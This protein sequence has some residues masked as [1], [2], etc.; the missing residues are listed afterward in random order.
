MEIDHCS[1]EHLPFSTLFKTY[2]NKFSELRDF[3][4]YD[5]FDD[6]SILDRSEFLNDYNLR[7]ELIEALSVYHKDLCISDNQ[8]EQ[9]TKFANVD[10]RVV[11][12]GQQT[13]LF[14]GPLFTVYKTLTTILLA[15]KMESITGKPVVPV[16]WI[17]DEDHDFDEIAWA[18][19]LGRDDYHA[20]TLD[21]QGSG[22]PV[23][24]EIIGSDFNKFESEFWDHLPDTDFT[25]SLK[26]QLAE[27][28][29]S[30]NTFSASFAQF[31]CELFA[32]QGILIAGSQHKV[33]KD[34]SKEVIKKSVT[35]CDKIFEAIET[36]SQQI[37]GKYHQQVQ[38]GDT[39]LFY[40]DHDKKRVKIHRDGS[41]FTAGDDRWSEDSLIKEIESRPE[42]FSPNVFLR[43]VIQDHLFPTIG[44]VAGPGE[45]AYYGQMKEMYPVFGMEMPVIYPRLSAT[46]LESGIER[47]LEKLPF[48][49]WDYGQRIEDLESAYVEKAETID[50]ESVFGK[51]MN[52]IK[53]LTPDAREKINEVD[54][55]LDGTVGKTESQFLNELNKLKGRVYRSI[56]E[57]EKIQINRIEKIKVNLFP[58]GGLQERSVSPVYIMNKY[59]PGIWDELADQLEKNDLDLSKHYIIKL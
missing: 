38:N 49:L 45:T 20:V 46:I 27:N 28:Y 32:D 23:S 13:G 43:P 35:E 26:K 57:Q 1:F 56:K 51:W 19:V 44:Y 25:D 9:L 42:R 12:T 40:L 22:K 39:N 29:L 16:F 10:S 14:G 3:Y 8:K 2:I 55:T 37:A 53:E 15:R 34:L 6:Q 59:G 36:K 47:I 17:A 24:E 48:E 21:Q 31:I 18:G 30:G 33:F 4:N 58:D 7:E 5:P 54:P 11:V 52:G 41:V 50:V